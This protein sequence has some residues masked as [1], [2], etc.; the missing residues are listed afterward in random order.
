MQV[1]IKLSV[2]IIK[3]WSVSFGIFNSLYNIV[4]TILFI[5]SDRV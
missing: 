5:F 4:Y 3:K 1:S 2:I